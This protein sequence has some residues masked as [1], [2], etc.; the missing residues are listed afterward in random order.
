MAVAGTAAADATVPGRKGSTAP[1]KERA[2][3]AA[4]CAAELGRA[5]DSLGL[6]GRITLL[7]DGS[8]TTDAARADQVEYMRGPSIA[9]AAVRIY[10][11]AAAAPSVW[12]EL[13]AGETWVRRYPRLHAWVYSPTGERA[14]IDAFRRAL[15]AC[16][17]AR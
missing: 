13:R 8:P 6:P 16:A 9:D 14:F 3:W 17:A 15:D 12:T 2:T 1:A 4:A 7:A 5:R 10:A 11:V